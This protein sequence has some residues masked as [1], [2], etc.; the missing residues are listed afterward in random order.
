MNKRQGRDFFCIICKNRFA[1]EE[2]FNVYYCAGNDS[3]IKVR[4]EGSILSFKV[5]NKDFKTPAVVRKDIYIK[6]F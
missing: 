1:I 4:E 6:L 5:S 2:S 3:D